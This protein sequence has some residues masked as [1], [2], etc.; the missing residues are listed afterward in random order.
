MKHKAVLTIHVFGPGRLS[1]CLNFVDQSPA[2]IAYPIHYADAVISDM[3][4]EIA[5]IT[6]VFICAGANY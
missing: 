3:K 2:S 6:G 1:T 4:V 5:S